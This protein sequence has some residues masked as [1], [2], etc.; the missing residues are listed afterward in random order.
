MDSKKLFEK[1]NN[2]KSIQP[3]NEWKIRCREIL[4]SQISNGQTAEEL[5]Q[6][7]SFSWKIFFGDLLPQWSRLGI[8]KPALIGYS[9]I[10]FL[11]SCGLVGV[12]ASNNTRPGDSLYIAKIIN[13]KAQFAITFDEKEKTKLN[14]EFAVNRAEEINQLL[15][16]PVVEKIV[17]QEKNKKVKELTSNFKKEIN[18]AK[19][20]ISKINIV[21]IASS[22][23]PNKDQQFFSANLGKD[24]QRIEISE[25]V[26]NSKP[27]VHTPQIIVANPNDSEKNNNQAVSEILE[28][29]EKLFDEKNYS[30]SIDKLNEVNTVINQ[31]ETNVVDK[32]KNVSE[33]ASTTEK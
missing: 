15:E 23:K 16:K 33:S 2:L 4:L 26:K 29:A 9:V 21:N 32:T 19:I 27:V 6:E 25:P 5:E 11:M 31:T 18:Q 22:N 13:E 30:K 10:V 1:L 24:N 12:Y 8:A 3:D 17:E 28:Q 7:K 20:R 14:L